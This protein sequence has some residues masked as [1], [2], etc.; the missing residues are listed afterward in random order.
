VGGRSYLGQEHKL[1]MQETAS[2]HR[3]GSYVT[4]YVCLAESLMNLARLLARNLE[5]PGAKSAADTF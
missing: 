1:K 4:H 3:N 2:G 5:M